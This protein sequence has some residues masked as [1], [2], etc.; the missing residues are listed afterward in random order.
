MCWKVSF[1]T[2]RS[3]WARML[4]NVETRSPFCSISAARCKSKARF[5]S[6]RR[7]SLQWFPKATATTNCQQMLFGPFWSIS[8]NSEHSF[9][10][11]LIAEE[12]FISRVKSDRP[13]FSSIGSAGAENGSLSRLARRGHSLG[14][15]FP[16]LRSVVLPAAVP[17]MKCSASLRRFSLHLVCSVPWHLVVLLLTFPS[18]A[19]AFQGHFAGHFLGP[20]GGP[21]KSKQQPDTG[22]SQVPCAFLCRSSFIFSVLLFFL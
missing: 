19:A 4:P 8:C 10:L 2:L 21:Q 7:K 9:R 6:W 5:A 13:I 17:G 12:P 3:N 11:R 18:C 15:S 16:T 22:S 1:P 20:P 14:V